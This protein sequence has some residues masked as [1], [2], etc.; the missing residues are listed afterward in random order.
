[1]GLVK[2]FLLGA[3]LNVSEA[4]QVKFGLLKQLWQPEEESF[5]VFFC[6]V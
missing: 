3:K 6:F 5:C 2:K 4:K 1:V